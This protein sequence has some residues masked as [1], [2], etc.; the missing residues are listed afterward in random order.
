MEL[1]GEYFCGNKISDYGIRNGYLDY[2][3]LAKSFNAVLANNILDVGDNWYQSS[4]GE[5]DIFQF[6]IV[7]EAGAEI[8]ERIGEIIFRNEELDLCVWGVTHFGTSWDYVL[9]NVPC[10]TKKV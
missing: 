3:T 2:G 9:T 7:D 10:C 5:D 4:G 8:L 1:Y 6:Y